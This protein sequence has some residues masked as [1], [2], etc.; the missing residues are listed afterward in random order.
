MSQIIIHNNNESKYIGMRDINSASHIAGN[1]AIDMAKHAL[2]GLLLTGDKQETQGEKDYNGTL[3]SRDKNVLKSEDYL[4]LGGYSGMDGAPNEVIFNEIILQTADGTFIQFI[5]AKCRVTK[6]NIVTKQEVV[7]RTGTVKELVRAND[8]SITISGNL[9]I[10]NPYAFPLEEMKNLIKI[11]SEES[12]I[13]VKS[14]LI[15]DIYGITKIVFDQC[16][17]DQSQ[18]N[19]CNVIPFSIDFTSDTNYDFEVENN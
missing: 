9:L 6:S 16:V 3:N 12:S 4:S 8:E 14:V 15:N 1:M 7:A 17:F 10:D 2:Y 11:L 18:M 5:D 13:A 19:Y